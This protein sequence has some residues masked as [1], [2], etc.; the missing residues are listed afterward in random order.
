MKLVCI[1]GG[2]N[3]MCLELNYEECT[4]VN[5]RQFRIHTSY[6]MGNRFI[7]IYINNSLYLRHKVQMRCCKP[8]SKLGLKTKTRNALSD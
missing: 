2:H 3:Y 1:R 4:T 6:T 5:V 7:Y 8:N